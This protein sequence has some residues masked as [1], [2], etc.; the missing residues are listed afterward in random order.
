MLLVTFLR[1]SGQTC[2]RARGNKDY[3]VEYCFI[4]P[5]GICFSLCML[6]LNLFTEGAHNMEPLAKDIL[7]SDSVIHCLLYVLLVLFAI[8]NDCNYRRCHLVIDCIVQYVT[9]FGLYT[10]NAVCW[11]CKHS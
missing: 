10:C 9:E 1:P 5:Q 8:I 2:A 11:E 3:S 7:L 4:E 6:V